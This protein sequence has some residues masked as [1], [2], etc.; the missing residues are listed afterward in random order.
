MATLLREAGAGF[1]VV[2]DEVRNLAMRAADAANSTAELIEG[3]VGKVKTG[4]DLVSATSDDFVEAAKNITTVS[5]LIGQIANASREQSLGISQINKEVG[6]IN[7]VAQDV[8][9]QADETAGVALSFAD[10]SERL[11]EIVHNLIYVLQGTHNNSHKNFT[12]QKE[13]LADQP[14]LAQE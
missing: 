2:A 4:T 10:Q 5:E 9:A 14:F 1:A 12:S 7:Q 11:Q 13:D 3:T 6:E 8:N